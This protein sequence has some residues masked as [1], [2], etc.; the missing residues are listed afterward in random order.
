MAAK[1]NIEAADV[2]RYWQLHQTQLLG[3]PYCIAEDAESG[4]EIELSTNQYTQPEITVFFD[5]DEVSREIC[6][7]PSDCNA[8][9]LQVYNDYLSSPVSAYQS[10]QAGKAAAPQSAKPVPDHG[11]EIADRWDELT[12]A[13][14]DLLT[15]VFPKTDIP[16]LDGIADEAAEKILWVL[17]REF[18]L[19]IYRPMWLEDD[20]GEFFEEYPYPHM[21][22]EEAGK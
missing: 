7:G 17:H 10:K 5:D 15:V 8:I 2:W 3:S 16:V 4:L 20:A 12:T 19:P 14:F 6:Y 1:V 11:A 21:V 9:V 18:K 22:Y 13:V